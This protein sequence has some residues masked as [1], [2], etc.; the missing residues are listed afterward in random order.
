M[1]KPRP[2]VSPRYLVTPSLSHPL[3]KNKIEKS[4]HGRRAF[5]IHDMRPHAERAEAGGRFGGTDPLAAPLQ[6]APQLLGAHHVK[7]RAPGGL[8]PGLQGRHVRD[9]AAAAKQDTSSLLWA[10]RKVDGRLME[11]GESE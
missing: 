11:G 1:L 3:L 10:R 7:P 9:E 2:Q 5:E 8:D 4:L 6:D